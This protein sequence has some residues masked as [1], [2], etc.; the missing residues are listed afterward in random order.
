LALQLEREQFERQGGLVS[1]GFQGVE[2]RGAQGT[3][4]TLGQGQLS[5]GV[6]SI[7]AQLAERLGIGRAGIETN[8]G[9]IESQRIIGD[10]AA[11][12]KRRETAFGTAGTILFGEDIGK[13][14]KAF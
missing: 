11:R 8:L 5:S 12:A 13:I 3:Q 2:R 14:T 10:A 9:D 4:L 1:Q 6:T 7:Q